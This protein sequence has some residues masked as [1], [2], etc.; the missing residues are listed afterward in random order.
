[1]A[2]R[3]RRILVALAVL[4]AL[5]V[6]GVFAAAWWALTSERALDWLAA[7]ASW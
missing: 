7:E 3:A 2:A 6:V 4:V 5:G 1:M